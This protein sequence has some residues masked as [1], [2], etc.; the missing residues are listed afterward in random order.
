MARHLDLY[1]LK[2]FHAL[3]TAGSFT[4]AAERLNLT[5]SAV[6]HAV[7]K[8]EASAG[9]PL[10]DRS[11]RELRLTEEG[12]R[13]FQACEE[14]FATLEAAA[15]DLAPPSARGRIRL[16]ATLEF[17]SS[18]L[19]RHIR[20]FLEAHPHIEVDFH[21]AEDLLAPLLRDELDIAIDCREHAGPGLQRLPWFVETYVAAASPAFLATRPIA[22]PM[23]LAGCPVLSLDK[24]GAWWNRLLSALP[25]GQRPELGRIIAVNQVR[26]MINAAAE[27]LG[28][29]LAPA[30]AVLGELERGDLVPLLPGVRPRE[31]RFAIYQKRRRAALGRH[32]LLTEFLLTLAPPEF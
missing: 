13:L 18:I 20:P 3:G 29:L 19:M 22:S 1:Q 8:L 28:L 17:G 30:Y 32:R 23:D 31:D 2:A 11:T 21:L 12:R 15:E 24:G 25:P 26:A 16:G 27:G 5:Q 9:L 10:V 14:V 7:A 6:S 4:R